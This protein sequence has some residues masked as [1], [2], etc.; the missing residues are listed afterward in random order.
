MV[1][2]LAILI[3]VHLWFRLW[4]N[5]RVR[6]TIRTDSMAAIGAW[7]KERSTTPS[8]NMVVRE[9]ALDFAEGLY[10]FDV[11]QHIEGTKNVLADALS[12]MFEPGSDAVL[13]AELEDVLRDTPS[14]RDRSWWK[15]WSPITARVWWGS[16]GRVA[17]KEVAKGVH[18]LGG[19]HPS[20][21]NA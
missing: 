10:A 13:P 14:V 7:S 1:E 20:H 15:V 11:V 6:V 12:R 17:W 8:I 2:N 18:R 19:N 9:M 5:Q 16:R 3:G 21:G 4:N